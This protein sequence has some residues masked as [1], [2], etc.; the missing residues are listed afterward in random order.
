VS[1]PPFLRAAELDAL[2]VEHGFGTRAS[3]SARIA[4]LRTVR[5]VHG[6]RV[7]RVPPHSGELEADALLTTEPGWAVAVRTADCVPI[8]L[9]DRERRGVAAVH[10]GWRGSAARIGEHAVHALCEAC[11][12]EPSDL[13]AVIGP[14]IQACCY[15]VDDPVRDQ[16]GE[17]SVF[18][19]ADRPGHYRLD[20]QR[21]NRLQL[22]RA[23][24]RTIASVGGCTSCDAE[25]Y[26]SYRRDGMAGR[27]I[28]YIKL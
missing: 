21:L 15:E 23:G 28:S 20:L 4:G 18:V 6:R 14:H 8:L 12:A 2:G 24:V 26:A 13:L 25:R 11:G 19:F 3:E 22:G 1:V 10:A 27:M 7:L 16:I 9:A 17:H 5:Q